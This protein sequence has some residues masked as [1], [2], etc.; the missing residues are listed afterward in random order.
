MLTKTLVEEL[1]ADAKMPLDFRDSIFF[2]PNL[3]RK[4]SVT[5]VSARAAAAA[6]LR[7][8]AVRGLSRETPG[9]SCKVST[10]EPYSFATTV[11]LQHSLVARARVPPT[12]PVTARDDETACAWPQEW[13]ITVGIHVSLCK[14]V[15]D[16]CAAVARCAWD[17]W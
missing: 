12:S 10:E 7:M 4:V 17:R 1:I 13:W 16:P 3:I 9:T 11:T 8:E 14:H 5:R 2:A 15:R 6:M